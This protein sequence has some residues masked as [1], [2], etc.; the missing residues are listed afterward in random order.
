MDK[1]VMSYNTLAEIIEALNPKS[2][3]NPMTYVG[4][5]YTK[6]ALIKDLKQIEEQNNGN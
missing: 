5:N 6:E 2:I 1:K 4:K 3:G